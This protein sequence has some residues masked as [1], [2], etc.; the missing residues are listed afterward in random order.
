MVT[1][2]YVGYGE[3][4]TGMTHRGNESV[5]NAYIVES[6]A[7]VLRVGRDLSL[8]NACPCTNL[9]VI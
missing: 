3:R 4:I 6:D 7:V 9:H 5:I 8:R 2:L 1:V